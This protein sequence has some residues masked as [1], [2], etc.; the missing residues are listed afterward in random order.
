[1]NKY[2]QI[3]N[4]QYIKT[5]STDFY[6]LSIFS[7]EI[8]DKDS[9]RL[10]NYID[11]YKNKK[12]DNF[13][14]INI[15][16]NCILSS[17][18]IYKFKSILIVPLFYTNYYMID[19]FIS[20]NDHDCYFCALNNMTSSKYAQYEDY[21]KLIQNVFERNSNIKNLNDFEKELDKIIQDYKI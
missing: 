7:K 19:Y 20:N 2:I 10:D 4:D 8:L 16:V 17:A 13:N 21:Y 3:K 18:L 11:Y 1:M 12:S 14:K 15:I 6:L 9:I 5:N